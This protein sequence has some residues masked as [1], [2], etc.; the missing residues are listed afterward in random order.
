GQ[1]G[2]RMAP[3]VPVE[4][5]EQRGSGGAQSDAQP[6]SPREPGAD[7]REPE[8]R[9]QRRD[10]EEYVTLYVGATGPPRVPLAGRQP[11]EPPRSECGE[12][13][14]CEEQPA[15][16]EMRDDEPADYRAAD[17]RRG[18]HQRKIT[19]EPEAL[20]RRNDFT[21]ERLRKHHQAAA[22]QPLQHA[23]GDEQQHRLRK[24][25]RER[26]ERKHPQRDEQDVALPARIAEP[27]VD[28]NDR[29]RSKQIRDRD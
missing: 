21:D 29:R 26:A 24:S 23:R 7:G 4:P 18:E 9:A 25:A 16:T 8:Q 2:S 11:A 6:E 12:R 14:I 10:H 19:L 1:K 5:G 20:E 17:A 22:T 28:R 13:Q 3:L 27:T 15:P